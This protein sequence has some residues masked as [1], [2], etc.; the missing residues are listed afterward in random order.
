MVGGGEDAAQNADILLGNMPLRALMM[1]N[2][3][4]VTHGM[5][6]G[7][8]MMINGQFFRGLGRMMKKVK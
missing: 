8:A 3:Q 6:E 1:L 4:R 5:V 2:G 7:I